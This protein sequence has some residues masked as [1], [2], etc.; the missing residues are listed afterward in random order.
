MEDIREDEIYLPARIIEAAARAIREA[1]A[2]TILNVS[3]S[4]WDKIKA[5][6]R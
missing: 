6:L 5:A 4:D 2:K 3:D 1:E